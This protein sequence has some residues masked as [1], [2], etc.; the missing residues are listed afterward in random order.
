MIPMLLASADIPVPHDL[1]LPL[2]VPRELLAVLLV[3]F[4]ALHILFVNLMVGGSILALVCE[5]LGLRRP[6]FDSLARRLAETITVNKSLAV[7]LGVGPL[8]AIN[9]LYSVQF[10]AANALT[11][12]AWALLVP[13]VATA[14][15]CT[16]AHKYSWD[17]LANRKALHLAIGALAVVQFLAIPFVFLANA[18]L[19]LFPDRWADVRGFFSALLLPNVLPRYFHFLLASLSVTALFGVGWFGHARYDLAA[20]LPGWTRPQVKRFFY[21]VALLATVAQFLV[22]PLLYF[23]L[24]P[25]GITLRLTAVILVGAAFGLAT[26]ALL[27]REVLGDDARIGRFFRWIVAGLTVTVGFMVTGRHEYREAALKPHRLAV[28]ARTAEYQRLVAEA[29]NWKPST[30]STEGLSP[31]DQGK[32]LYSQTCSAC[33]QPAGTGVPG[34]F[35]PLAGSEWVLAPKPDRLVRIVLHGLSG[36]ITVKGQTYNSVMPGQA[37][38]LGD[39]QIAAVLTYIRS[40]WGNTASPVSASDVASARGSGRA[41]WTAAELEG[42][43][44]R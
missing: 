12:T 29:K 42:V 16:Y 27:V 44:D 38:T 28:E 10:Y 34:A 43:A 24:P 7:V 21:T 35:P 31:A 26:T 36:P 4:F 6:A 39:D 9:L 22:G 33:H 32:L 20:D 14:F 1:A 13:M 15:L 8:L 30:P 2:P 5:F 40:A 23:T 25:Q 11:G 3:V 18:N 41:A 19:M 17:R 37:Q